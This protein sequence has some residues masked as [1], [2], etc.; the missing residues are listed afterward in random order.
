MPV[1]RRR[2]RSCSTE[3]AP[4]APFVPPALRLQ[5]AVGVIVACFGEPARGQALLD[6]LRRAVLEAIGA[7]RARQP[8]A[9]ARRGPRAGD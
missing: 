6:G 4:P 9:I 8:E 7:G 5:P 1:T 2:D 3:V